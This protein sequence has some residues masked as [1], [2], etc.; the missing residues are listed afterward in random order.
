MRCDT[1][2]LGIIG[3]RKPR[4]GWA[5]FKRSLRTETQLLLS[6][7]ASNKMATCG[8]VGIKATLQAAHM[9]I[10]ESADAAAFAKLQAAYVSVFGSEDFIEGREAEAENRRPIFHGR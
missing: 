4:I 3:A 6:E 7:S 9:A 2:S 8:P 5:S 1:C 10:D